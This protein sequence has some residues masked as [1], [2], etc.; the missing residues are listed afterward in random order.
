MS[1]RLDNGPLVLF[2][3]L[4]LTDFFLSCSSEEKMGVEKAPLSRIE[5]LILQLKDGSKVLKKALIAFIIS[6]ELAT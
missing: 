3:V 5:S 4:V 1:S 2:R 6:A